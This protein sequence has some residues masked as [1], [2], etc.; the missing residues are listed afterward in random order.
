MIKEETGTD[1]RRWG[2]A[3]FLCLAVVILGMDDGVLNLAL[4][5]ISREL[6]GST[7]DMQWAIN[8]YI[9]AFA[10]LLLT[11]GAFGDRFGRKRMFLAGMIVFCLSSLAAALSTSMTMLIACRALMGIGGAI[12]IPQSLSIITATF[13]DVKERMQAIA[14][15]AAFFSLGYGI[16]PVVGGI[17]LNH[18]EWHSVFIINIPLAIIAFAGG[19]FFARESKNQSAPRLD[20]QGVLLSAAGLFLLVYGIIEAGR[21]SWTEGSVIIWLS[22][23]SL[24][25]FIFA[26]WEIRTDHPMLPMKLFKNMSFTGATIPM[27]MIYFST[28]ALLFFFSQYFQSVQGYSPLAAAVRIL[29]LAL[30]SFLVSIA[31]APISDRIGIKLTVA[32]GSLLIMASLFW[33]SSVTAETP[34]LTILGPTLIAGVGMGLVWTAAS[35]SVMGSLPLSRAGI[36]SSM[37]ATLQQTG[38]VLGVAALGSV[39]NGVYVDKIA[40]LKVAASL[41]EESYEAMRS[42]IQ[43][44][45]I[46]AEQYPEDISQ[47]IIHGAND[48]FTSGMVEAMFIGGIV[49]AVTTLFT[50]IVLPTRIRPARE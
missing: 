30:I 33:F 2:A 48:A 47:Q 1:S 40:G 13:T 24:L 6:H 27:T 15:W 22:I 25:L 18:F 11:M 3:A 16:G 20:P 17:L 4:P 29:P 46:V 34:Y 38:A 49:M 45:H 9:L 21:L 7:S 44:A 43:G 28:G 50:L 41:P 5:S 23:G 19:Y 31:A 8:A 14:L 10:A 42:S 32:L 12:A 26:C 39:L 35:N 37:D 36:G